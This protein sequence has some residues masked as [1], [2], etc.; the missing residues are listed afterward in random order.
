MHPE[1]DGESFNFDIKTSGCIKYLIE[2]SD[3]KSRYKVTL[4]EM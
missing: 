4:K 3:E 2:G 1:D